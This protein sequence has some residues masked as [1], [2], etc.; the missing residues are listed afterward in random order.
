MVLQVACRGCCAIVEASDNN[1]LAVLKA[2]ALLQ[3]TSAHVKQLQDASKSAPTDSNPST[4]AGQGSSAASTGPQGFLAALQPC[5]NILAGVLS[6]VPVQ[7]LRSQAAVALHQL[8]QALPQ[9][10]CTACLQQLLAGSAYAVAG[11]GDAVAGAGDAIAGAVVH[12]EVAA[13]LMQEVRSLL[14]TATPGKHIRHD[15]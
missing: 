13:L 7:A 12:P 1:A 4:D 9:R 6:Q 11:A 2:I 3:L 15:V 14:V 10:T 5:I 8:L